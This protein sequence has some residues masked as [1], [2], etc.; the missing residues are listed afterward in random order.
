MNPVEDIRVAIYLIALLFFRDKFM[1]RKLIVGSVIAVVVILC[2][3]TWFSGM[4]TQTSVEQF[5]NGFNK[6]NK[7]NNGAHNMTLSR[8]DYKRGFLV[9][10]F[11][12][13]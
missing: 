4:K 5:I 3:G 1:I 12:L 11:K 7:N 10:L 13:L 9:H 2:G 6:A 8:K